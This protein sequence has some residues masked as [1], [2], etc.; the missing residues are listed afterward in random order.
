[1]QYLFLRA[2]KMSTVDNKKRLKLAD[3]ERHKRFVE[4]AHKLDVPDEADLSP[5]FF[6]RLVKPSKSLMSK[7]T[8]PDA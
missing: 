4:M 2:I 5:E 1:M 6:K 3:V 8:K 7:N